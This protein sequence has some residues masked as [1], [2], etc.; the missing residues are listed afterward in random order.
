MIVK[1]LKSNL[2]VVLWLAALL[3]VAIVLLLCES[4]LLWKIQEKNL[5]LCSTLFLKEQ[6]VVPGGLLTWIGMWFTQFLYYPWLGVLMLCCW[7]W[8]LMFLI[9]RTFRIPARWAILMLIPVA[10]LL[11]TNM[12]LGYWIYMLKLRGHFFIS[13]I[14]TTAVVALLWGFRCIPDKY[15]LRAVYLLVVCA[16]GYPLMGIYAL[17]AVLLMGIWSWRLSTTRIGAVV[18]S[19]LAVLGVI[20]V[21]LFCYRYI[22]RVE[23]EQEQH[24]HVASREFGS[25]RQ[26]R[27]PCFCQW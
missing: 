4:H 9:K 1:Y 27:L 15:Y 12:E 19:V 10:L 16:V 22:Y 11:L 23:R 21:P 5:F 14:G 20:A 13:T 18:H 8:L 17:A 6:L 7:W 26:T 2:H 3:A 24:C 25:S